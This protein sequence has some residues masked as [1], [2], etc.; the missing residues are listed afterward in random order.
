MWLCYF[1]RILSLKGADYFQYQFLF[2]FLG[3]TSCINRICLPY[4]FSERVHTQRGLLSSIS[5]M[6]YRK[7]IN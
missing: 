4:F 2:S 6:N 1:S 3:G 5:L 7:K